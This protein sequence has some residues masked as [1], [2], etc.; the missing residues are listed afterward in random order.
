MS[1]TTLEKDESVAPATNDVTPPPLPPK[2][3]QV[4]VFSPPA[5]APSQ[6]QEVPESFYKLD[7]NQ[8]AKLYKA[9]VAHRQNLENSPL[10]TQKMRNA[11]E[12]ER[13]KK[14][15]KTT[16]RVRFPDHTILQ[17]VFESKETVAA[18]Y[19]FIGSTLATP[20]R[21]FLLCLPPRQKLTEPEVSLYK[22]GLAP[23]SNVMFVWLDRQGGQQQHALSNHYLNQIK[24][25]SLPSSSVTDTTAAPSSTPNKSSSSTS[26]SSGGVPKW[27]KKGLFKK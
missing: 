10:K 24:P 8:V 20:E 1:S 12:L 15:P 22:A 19:E 4:Q 23:A 27:L 25:L 2:D 17:A 16:I 14:Y 18:L 3:R 9:Q 11:E 6:A 7:S 13:M 21:A 26:S 5:N